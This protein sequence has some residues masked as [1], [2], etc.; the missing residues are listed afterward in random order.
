[1]I[2]SQ[3]GTREFEHA[4]R[5]KG[6]DQDHPVRKPMNT[7]EGEH[8]EMEK[9]IHEVVAEHGPAHKAVIH[10]HHK[11]GHVHSAEHHD[12]HSATEHIQAAM[13]AGDTE[14]QSDMEEPMPHHSLPGMG[15]K[16]TAAN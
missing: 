11:D 8:D 15:S 16:M 6:Y 10:T 14:R 3:D 5:A 13:G 2:K 1:M 7:G 12:A 4:G 9:P